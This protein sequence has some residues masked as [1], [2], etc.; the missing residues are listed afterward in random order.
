MVGIKMIGLV[1]TPKFTIFVDTF[2]N[3]QTLDVSICLPIF[4][5]KLIPRNHPLNNNESLCCSLKFK[6]IFDFCSYGVF[7]KKQL[8][9]DFTN[10]KT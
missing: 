9:H 2:D 8:L 3:I 10:N 4:Y 7:I 5:C 1:E 6:I